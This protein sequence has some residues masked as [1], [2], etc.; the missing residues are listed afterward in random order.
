MPAG[1]LVAHRD[2]PL[3]GNVDLHQLDDA[4]R[5]LVGLEDLVDLILRL[6][7][8][9]GALGAGGV[10][11]GTDFLVHRLVGDAQRLQIDVGKVNLAELL[12]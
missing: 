3:L 8:D 5:Q 10:E 11:Y 7:L 4:G 6:L 12:P 9:L 2:L 1:H